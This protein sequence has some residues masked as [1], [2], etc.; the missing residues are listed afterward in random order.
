MLPIDKTVILDVND[1][2]LQM[3]LYSVHEYCTKYKLTVNTSK[4]K[5]IIFL[6]LYG[7]E[8]WGFPRIHM[9]ELFILKLLGINLSLLKENR[10]L[11]IKPYF[12]TIY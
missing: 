5:M 11:Y 2:D 8:V 10:Q 12:Y 7:C 6:L 4:T 9:S 1:H 3:A